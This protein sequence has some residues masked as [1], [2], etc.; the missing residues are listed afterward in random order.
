[1][2]WL[3]QSKYGYVWITL[4]FFTI[5]IIGQWLFGWL[6]YVNEQHDHNAAVAVND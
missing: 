2:N 3:R 1:M 4:A 6:A 5:S